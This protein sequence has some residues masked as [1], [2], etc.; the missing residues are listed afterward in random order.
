[1]TAFGRPLTSSTFHTLIALLTA[2][3]LL[4]ACSDSVAPIDAAADGGA[5]DAQADL[6]RLDAAPVDAT[7]KPDVFVPFALT[8]TVNQIP[9]GMNGSTPFTN[10]AGAAESFRLTVPRHGFTLDVLFAGSEAQPATL[11]VT[12]DKDLGGGS[13]L[14]QAG[15]DLVAS[16]F[17]TAAGRAA[18]LVPAGLAL[19][20][21]PVTF[22]ASM[23]DGAKTLSGQLSVNAAQKTFMLDPFR[24]ED[25]WLVVMDQDHYTIGLKQSAAGALEVQSAAK[26]NGVA[27]LDEDLRLIGLGTATMLPA[28]AKTKGRGATGTNAIIEAWIGGEIMTALRGAYGL[29][30]DGSKSVDSVKIAFLRQTDPGAPTLSSLT[31]QKLTGGETKKNFSAISIGGGD[32]SK[33]YLGLSKTVDPRNLKNEPNVGP[34]YGVFSTKAVALVFSLV[35]SD[36]TVKLLAQTFFGEFVPALGKGGKPVGEHALDATIL[37]DGF[38]PKKAAGPAQARHQKLTFLVE[39]LGRLIGALTAHESGHALGLVADGPPPYGLFGGEKNAAFVTGSRT[40]SAHIDT[41]GFNLM[42]AGPGTAPGAT[43]NIMQYLTTPR[44]NALNLAYL[45]GRVLLLPKLTP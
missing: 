2:P 33:P 19:P 4:V 9:A 3:L 39:T 43:L 32:L 7:I 38:D 41:T 26:P 22:S 24:L 8:L 36:P 45:Q 40:T 17:S 1:M 6:Q 16:G 29:A 11:K 14:V 44:F 15:T 18:L 12:A 23:S 25:T 27:D 13:T 5:P 10:L 37:A 28:A 21:G 31:L 35:D 34:T 20:E 42:E 30:P